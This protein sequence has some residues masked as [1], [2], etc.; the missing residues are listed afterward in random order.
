MENGSGRRCEGIIGKGA[1]DL[2]EQEIGLIYVTILKTASNLIHPDSER[3]SVLF[4]GID[5]K[6]LSANFVQLIHY[7]EG[8]FRE[9]RCFPY[10]KY[11]HSRVEF[12]NSVING[13]V[14]ILNLIES[15]KHRTVSTLLMSLEEGHFTVENVSSSFGHFDR[16]VIFCEDESLDIITKLKTHTNAEIVVNNNYE[17]Y[18]SEEMAANRYAKQRFFTGSYIDGKIFYTSL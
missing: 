15:V 3:I 9:F 16:V 10:S 17:K 13:N 18:I 2:S 5:R 12:L 8:I 7:E 6:I 14:D 11:V 4:N 1:I